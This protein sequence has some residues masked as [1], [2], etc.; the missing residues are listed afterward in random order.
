MSAF[1]ISSFCKWKI[2]IVRNRKKKDETVAFTYNTYLFWYRFNILWR[3][4][5]RL[6]VIAA[7]F[8]QAVGVVFEITVRFFVCQWLTFQLNGTKPHPRKRCWIFMTLEYVPHTDSLF[9][10]YPQLFLVHVTDFIALGINTCM[11]AGDNLQR[12]NVILNYFISLRI[13]YLCWL[14][15]E[16]Q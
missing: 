6:I 13:T 8:D 10:R 15:I 3:E 1:I 11:L 2:E 9:I 16:W 5:Q 4:R 7:W 12:K 14:L